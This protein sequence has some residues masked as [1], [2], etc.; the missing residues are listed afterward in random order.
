MRDAALTE[1]E[2]DVGPWE[3]W[4]V[5]TYEGPWLEALLDAG[6]P[7]VACSPDGM[8]YTTTRPPGRTGHGLTTRWAGLVVRTSALVLPLVV[9]DAEVRAA[10]LSTLQLGGARRAEDLVL[11]LRERVGRRV[12]E[13]TAK[14]CGRAGLAVCWA[15]VKAPPGGAYVPTWAASLLGNVPASVMDEALVLCRDD[16][17]A[18]EVVLATVEALKP[19]PRE[20]RLDVGGSQN[21]TC[22]AFVDPKNFHVVA[23]VVR[24]PADLRR[25]MVAALQLSG[26]RAALDLVGGTFDPRDAPSP[27]PRP[28]A[29]V[30][31]DLP[32]GRDG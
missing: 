10:L 26:Q 25:A 13:A 5:A 32:G 20:R 2:S 18:R 14:A 3:G 31:T 27:R 29:E 4:T 19:V 23:A 28:G 30:L 11:S 21:T 17:E 22:V 15:G 9:S 6:A 1:D 8:R 24:A 16:L 7:V 12:G